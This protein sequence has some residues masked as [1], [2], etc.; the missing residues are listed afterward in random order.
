MGEDRGD[1]TQMRISDADRDQAASVLS[2][3]L[4]EGRLTADEHAERL[5]AIYASKNYAEILPLVRDLPGAAAALR[6]QSAEL[7]RMNA[8]PVPIG[9]PSSMVAVFSNTSRRGLWR[10]PGA[11]AAVSIFGHAELDLRDAIL[12]GKEVRIRAVCVLG[13]VRVTVPPEMHVVDEGWA[14]LGG[15]EF[16]PDS[17][18]SASPDA[19]VLRI[20]GVSILGLATVRRKKRERAL[21]DEHRDHPQIPAPGQNTP[22]QDPGSSA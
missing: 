8:S 11:I 19:P 17:E 20:S 6:A 3:A 22:G 14:L 18:E 4:A 5:D 13:N 15:R 2:A 9:R 7:E 21:R 1:V 12:P 10:V 16:P